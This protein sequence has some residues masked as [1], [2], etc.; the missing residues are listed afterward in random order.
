MGQSG[1]SDVQTY[2]NHARAGSSKFEDGKVSAIIPI[3]FRR[4][5]RS[6]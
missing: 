1:L 2:R 6:H 5:I 4:T 3:Q